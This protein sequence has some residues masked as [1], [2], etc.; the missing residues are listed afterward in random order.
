MS[1]RV[2]QTSVDTLIYPGLFLLGSLPSSVPILS[3]TSTERS[4][5]FLDGDSPYP[6]FNQFYSL[7]QRNWVKEALRSAHVRT[8]ANKGTGVWEGSRIQRWPSRKGWAKRH[9]VTSSPAKPPWKLKIQIL[10]LAGMINQWKCFGL[11]ELKLNDKLGKVIY[12][13]TG[14]DLLF[15][16]ILGALVTLFFFSG[17]CSLQFTNRW[18]LRKWRGESLPAFGFWESPGQCQTNWHQ[19]GRAGSRR[20]V[21]PGR[22]R[23]LVAIPPLHAFWV[24]GLLSPTHRASPTVPSC[25][26]EFRAG[27]MFLYQGSD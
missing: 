16:K 20:Q 2:S 12:L 21:M 27:L 17:T 8:T 18:Y 25:L 5:G 10:G 6:C 1:A 22:V 23:S 11:C 24:L 3:I 19:L 14:V 26:C 9:W 7:P 4:K 15:W 13:C